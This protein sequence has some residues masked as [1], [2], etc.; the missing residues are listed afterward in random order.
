MMNASGNDDDEPCIYLSQQVEDAMDSS[1]EELQDDTDTSLAEEEEMSVSDLS[2]TDLH[3]LFDQNDRLGKQDD[4][5]RVSDLINER[6]H[7]YLASYQEAQCEAG[8]G[9]LSAEE[10]RVLRSDMYFNARF[11]IYTNRGPPDEDYD[12]AEIVGSWVS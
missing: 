4:N 12:P 6:E 5:Q 1:D 9:E 11:E 7:E 2:Y 3:R 8:G 10:K